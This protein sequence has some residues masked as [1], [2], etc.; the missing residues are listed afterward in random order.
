MNNIQQLILPKTI[1]AGIEAWLVK[2]DLQLPIEKADFLIL[3]ESERVRAMSFETHADQV[4]SVATRAAVRKLIAN[5]VA[6]PPNELKFATNQYGKPF[7]QGSANIDFNVA[8][9]G[10][11]A[12]IA[13]STIGQVGVDI[14]NCSRQLDARALTEYVFT[15]VERQLGSLSTE[16]FFKHWVAKESV[17]KAVGIGI[18]EHLQTI[19]ILPAASNEMDYRIESDCHEWRDIKVWLIEVPDLYAAAVAVK[20]TKSLFMVA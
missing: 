4:R 17:L 6:V 11:Y 15:D 10:H 20:A 3:S 9:T 1:P 13:I 5:K 16:N 2:L 14:E 7:L 18:S 8:H 12:L 19:S